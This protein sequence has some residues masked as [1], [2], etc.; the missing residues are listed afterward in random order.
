MTE[1][2]QKIRRLVVHNV[3][4]ADDTPHRIAWG[5]AIGVF[6]G[7]TPTVGVQMM[8][9]VALATALRGNK[10][11][12]IPMVWITNPVTILPIYALCHRLGSGLLPPGAG[13]EHGASHLIALME[14]TKTLGVT[15]V[16]E[17]SFW[18]EVFI[19]LSMVGAELWLGCVIVGFS[20]ATISYFASRWAVNVYRERRRELFKRRASR[21]T[22]RAFAKRVRGRE[23]SV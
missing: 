13:E 22:A 9:A 8:L 5:V 4:H 14:Q 2:W 19:G 12:C 17:M 11:V 6:V 16:L 3:L 20:A 18:K 15:R 7:L 21:R 1:T 23:P 10:I